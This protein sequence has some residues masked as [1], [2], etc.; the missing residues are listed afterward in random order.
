VVDAIEAALLLILPWSFVAKTVALAWMG[1]HLNVRT[2]PTGPLGQRIN[3]EFRDQAI[4][5]GW[6]TWG[7][8][9]L[10]YGLDS[11]EID[12]PWVSI[13]LAGMSLWPFRAAWSH[14]R[15][16]LTYRQIAREKS[17]RTPGKDGS[18]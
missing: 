2:K 14:F 8:F 15:V 11:S 16:Y 12:W 13:A 9:L 6:I 1:W 4:M 7:M 3:V 10:S 5:S 17:A 18:V